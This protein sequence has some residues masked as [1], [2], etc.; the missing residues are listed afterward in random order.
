MKGCQKKWQDMIHLQSAQKS[1][2]S[3][4]IFL[5]F[6]PLLSWM[7]LQFSQS[8][9]F[10]TGNRFCHN[11]I[12]TSPPHVPRW[13]WWQCTLSFHHHDAVNSFDF[14]FIFCTCM[15]F[16]FIFLLFAMGFIFFLPSMVNVVLRGKQDFFSNV[17]FL[18]DH[19]DVFNWLHC[20]LHFLI[21][22]WA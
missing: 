16:S 2:L 17:L 1:C 11:H 3:L 13:Q 22:F 5:H 8:R 12:L 7:Q 15:Y 19:N 10:C 4:S 9:T 18:P 6:T 20:W 14:H 21:F